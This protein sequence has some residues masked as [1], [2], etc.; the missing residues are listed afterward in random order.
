MLS[1]SAS[2]KLESYWAQLRLVHADVFGLKIVKQVSGPLMK[3]GANHSA[4]PE[5]VI[6]GPSL[7]DALDVYLTQKGKGR[8][9]SFEVAARRACGYVID[10]CTNK[11][12][13]AFDRSDALKFR[14]WLIERGLTG[15]SVTR[16]FSYVKAVINFAVSELALEVK[17]PF[18]GVYHDRQAGV[19]VRQP[20]PVDSIRDVQA[21]CRALD[22]DIRHLIAL[23]SDTGMRLAEAAG[24][25][26]TDFV[27]LDGEL[28]PE[29]RTVT[30]AMI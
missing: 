12:L 30:E 27:D 3:H 10:A 7:M 19:E 23:I 13:A 29:N 18:I 25:A 1:L 24:L 15:S 17:N 2:A 20:I 8:P 21:A 22:D 4:Q 9:K 11:P 28:P 26:L 5:P 14:N 16:N 6:V